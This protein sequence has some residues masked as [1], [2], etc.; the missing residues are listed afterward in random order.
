MATPTPLTY[1]SRLRT[2]LQQAKGWLDV[3]LWLTPKDCEARR[4][5]QRFIF[6][7][8]FAFLAGNVFLWALTALSLNRLDPAVSILKWFIVVSLCMA[9]VQVSL[10]GVYFGA[11]QNKTKMS[12]TRQLMGGAVGATLGLIC[13]LA[14]A[15]VGAS[16]GGRRTVFEIV[17]DPRVQGFVGLI[18][19]VAIVSN[20]VI[21]WLSRLRIREAELQATIAEQ[22]YT[23]ANLARQSSDA[24]LKLLQAQVEPHFL[25][26]TLANLRY[27]VQTNSQQALPMC[28]HLIEYLRVSL[29]SFRADRVPLEAELKLVESYLAIMAIRL[30]GSF[31]Y[32]V[33]IQSELAAQKIPPLMV[34]TLAEN[35]IKHGVTRTRDGGHI[36]VRVEAGPDLLRIVVEDTGA[37]LDAAPSATA[38]GGG[39]VGI[40]NLRERLDALYKGDGALTLQPNL[41]RGVIATLVIPTAGD[42]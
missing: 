1:A 15:L 34:L 5:T 21:Q 14:G 39:K 11:G 38:T 16:L 28:D 26:N 2:Y 41:P 6:D 13:G 17:S 22:A 7:H 10:L 25:Y 40:A 35:A 42:Y 36:D 32:R 31:T 27:L 8:W 20:I 18:A 4:I 12:R 30:A 37:G 19:V 33:Q 29:P 24:Q 9:T 3:I 23:S